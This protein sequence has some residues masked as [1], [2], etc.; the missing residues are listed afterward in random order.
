LSFRPIETRLNKLLWKSSRRHLEGRPVD[1][2]VD[3]TLLPYH[4]LPWR[5]RRE[6]KKSVAKH[7][8]SHFHAYATAS[9][10]RAGRRYTIACIFVP[11]DEGIARKLDRVLDIVQSHD[12]RVRALFMDRGFYAAEACALLRAR[13]IPFVM[14]IP[15]K[16]TRLRRLARTRRSYETQYTVRGRSADDRAVAFTARLIVVKRH[17]KSRLKRG[18]T[19]LYLV[20]GV[21]VAVSGVRQLYQRRFGI[22]STYKL[23]NA[24]RARTSSRDPRLR[25]LLVGV[26]LL[27]QNAW[28][29]AKWERFG[30][31]SRGQVG[32]KID[33]RAFPLQSMLRMIVR[34]VEALYEAADEVLL[35]QKGVSVV[36]EVLIVLSA[37]DRATIACAFGGLG[38]PPK[39]APRPANPS[40]G[41]TLRFG[42][43]R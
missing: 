22:E 1:I 23:M 11:A 6:I 27:V 20:D 36:G 10:L 41:V 12:L 35:I 17:R 30:T 21:P 25:L 8:T 9:V 26:A 34:V 38:D 42:R 2:A 3:L 40:Q 28:V 43:C 18:K 13:G 19:Y 16:G 32:R 39:R 29:A 33:E 7:G 37:R 15:M 24:C 5:H 31:P 4:G 14:A